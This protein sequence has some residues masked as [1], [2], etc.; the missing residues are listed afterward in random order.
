MAY[1]AAILLTASRWACFFSPTLLISAT[2]AIVAVMR[3]EARTSFVNSGVVCTEDLACLVWMPKCCH[4]LIICVLRHCCFAILSLFY[5]IFSLT[6]AMV[7]VAETFTFVMSCAVRT[8][9]CFMYSCRY[10]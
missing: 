10:V 8:L 5:C 4:A 9:H 7:T 2:I 6:M 3:H 1:V